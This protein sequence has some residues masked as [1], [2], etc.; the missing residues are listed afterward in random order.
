MNAAA[1]V[2]RLPTILERKP[3][4]FPFTLA[5]NRP[6][7]FLRSRVVGDPSAFPSSVT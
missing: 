6:F 5:L 3:N 1:P 4:A 7:V 2:A